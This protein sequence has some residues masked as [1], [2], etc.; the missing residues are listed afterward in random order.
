MPTCSPASSRIDFH[1]EGSRRFPVCSRDAD[2]FHFFLKASRRIVRD[3]GAGDAR[4]LHDH[5]GGP[6]MRGKRGRESLRKSV[7]E[8]FPLHDDRTPR[9]VQWRTAHSD[10]RRYARRP[11][12][13]K[14]ERSRTRRESVVIPEISTSG[15][16]NTCTTGTSLDEPRQLSSQPAVMNVF[17]ELIEYHCFPHP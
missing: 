3:N 17:P 2:E 1:E 4:I 14:S 10:D 15:G 12:A 8:L 13:M 9:L 6:L 5:D 7:H 16:P 11:F